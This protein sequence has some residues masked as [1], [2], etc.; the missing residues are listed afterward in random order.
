MAYKDD[1]KRKIL[2]ED[3]KKQDNTKKLD[4]IQSE[5]IKF[6]KGIINSKKLINTLNNDLGL[7]V[8]KK[9]EQMLVN[10]SFDNKNFGSVLKN[11]EILKDDNT[12]YR[13]A[14]A[15]LRNYSYNKHEDI[16]LRKKLKKSKQSNNFVFHY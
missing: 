16:E 11:L 10:P 15:K 14:S 6:D 3:Q 13:Q 7:K 5:F 9:L 4:R 1:F 2:I 8:S 12:E